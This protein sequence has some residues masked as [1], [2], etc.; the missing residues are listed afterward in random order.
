MSF[1]IS[2][3]DC[4]LPYNSIFPIQRGKVCF[5]AVTTIDVRKV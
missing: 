1:L 3:A 5:V 4:F 2:R